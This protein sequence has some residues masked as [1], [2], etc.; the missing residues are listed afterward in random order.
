MTSWTQGPVRRA[1]ATW[2]LGLARAMGAQLPSHVTSAQAALW[3][4]GRLPPDA[5]SHLE[6]CLVDEDLPTFTTLDAVVNSA[7]VALH[8]VDAPDADGCDDQVGKVIDLLVQS[9]HGST[10]RDSTALVHDVLQEI[11]DASASREALET[12]ARSWAAVLLSM[13]RT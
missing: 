1:Q 11:S 3:D 12:S 6:T 9:P 7:I 10:Y 4:H 13:P 5:L 2:L 8:Y